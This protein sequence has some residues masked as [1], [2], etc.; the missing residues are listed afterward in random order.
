MQKTKNAGLKLFAALLIMGVLPVFAISQNQS[1][2]THEFGSLMPLSLTSLRF[3]GFLMCP[4]HQFADKLT[5][6]NM[7]E[8]A[9]MRRPRMDL[10]NE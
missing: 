10:V 3:N 1:D 9:G 6:A 7:M 2:D 8:R 4:Y 5:G